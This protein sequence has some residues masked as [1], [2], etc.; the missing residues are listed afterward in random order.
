MGVEGLYTLTRGELA[1]ALNAGIHATNLDAGFY[2]AKLGAKLRHARG[3]LSFA[4]LPSVLIA[5]TERD[6]MPANKDALFIPV[7]ATYKL[8]SL[9]SLGFG[10]G[11]KGALEGFGNA[12]E[13]PLG[14]IGT[15]TVSPQLGLGASWV[16]GKVLGGADDPP[17]PAPEAT[18][19]RYRALQVWASYTH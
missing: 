15:V 3:A 19:F 5:L 18:G 8:S 10:T 13:F 7:V 14:V 4:A 6:G 11:I 17:D 1:F 16:F 2:V 12:W 9:L